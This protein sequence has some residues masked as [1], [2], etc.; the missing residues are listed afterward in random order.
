MRKKGTTTTNSACVLLPSNIPKCFG[1]H[2][3]IK[4]K[5]IAVYI[6]NRFVCDALNG[7][8][9]KYFLYIL[10]D[11]LKVYVSVLLAFVEFYS[12][13]QPH[14]NSANINKRNQQK[15]D[16]VTKS[17]YIDTIFFE[18][19]SIDVMS[20]QNEKMN[21]RIYGLFEVTKPDC[22]PFLLAKCER[23]MKKKL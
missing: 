13:H 1:E 6:A 18:V 21:K 17:I 15:K 4:I 19:I 9:T 7:M 10:H 5:Y 12:P 11:K 16:K 14:A 2:G 22:N 8:T 3:N 23:K 20:D